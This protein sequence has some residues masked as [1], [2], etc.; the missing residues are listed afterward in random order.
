MYFRI[1]PVCF[2]QA[3]SARTMTKNCSLSFVN[4]LLQRGICYMKRNWEGDTM[5]ALRD[6]LQCLEIEPEK[7]E[8][9]FWLVASLLSL[10]QT[11]LAKKLYEMTHSH[12]RNYEEKFNKLLKKCKLYFIRLF[13]KQAF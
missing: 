10:K 9:N 4:I 13:K 12:L 7:N 8:A 3:T 2:H 11:K 5:S 1:S 6:F